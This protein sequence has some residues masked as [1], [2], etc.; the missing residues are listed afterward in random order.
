MGHTET[1]SSH[2]Y[3]VTH[4]NYT[5]KRQGDGLKLFTERHL[6]QTCKLV[7]ADI[8]RPL[9]YKLGL[10]CVIIETD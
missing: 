3:R 9:K 5:T 8:L 7:D 4:F 1:F 10:K 2:K 6:T